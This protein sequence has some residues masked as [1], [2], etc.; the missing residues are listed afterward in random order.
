MASAIFF[1][2]SLRQKCSIHKTLVGYN[3]VVEHS[4]GFLIIAYVL[5]VMVNAGQYLLHDLVPCLW[6]RCVC[7]LLLHLTHI[8]YRIIQFLLFLLKLHVH[9]VFYIDLQCICM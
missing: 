8:Y 3:L 2:K 4:E 6:G 1:C 9:F 5:D 7:V